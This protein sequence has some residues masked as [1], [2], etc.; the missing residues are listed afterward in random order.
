MAEL[1]NITP[2]NSELQDAVAASNDMDW[3]E[4]EEGGRLK[5]LWTGA[6]TGRWV[7]LFKWDKGFVAAPHK[8]LSAAC[9][10]CDVKNRPRRQPVET[11]PGKSAPNR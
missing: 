10:S 11:A 7:V 3:I 6:E 1:Q 9:N 2:L 8:H 4:Y 5:V